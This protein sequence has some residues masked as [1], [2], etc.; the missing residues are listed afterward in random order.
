MRFSQQPFDNQMRATWTNPV[1]RSSHYHDYS[2]GR[3]LS[4]SYMSGQSDW[5]RQGTV[6]SSAT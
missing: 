4:Q 6:P 3:H 2:S 1:D 5:D